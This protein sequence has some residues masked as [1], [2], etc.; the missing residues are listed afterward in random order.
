MAEPSD[1]SSEDGGY[2]R[3]ALNTLEVHREDGTV[4]DDFK[5]WAECVLLGLDELPDGTLWYA[6]S[7]VNLA[8]TSVTNGN[9]GVAYNYA[10][11]SKSV[12]LTEEG[13]TSL[14]NTRLVVLVFK[15][16][17]RDSGV[18]PLIATMSIPLSALHDTDRLKGAFPLLPPS[19]ALYAP[20]GI[21]TS[22]VAYTGTLSCEVRPSA[23][24]ERYMLG[25]RVLTL[26]NLRVSNLP[27][28]WI[29]DEHGK[30]AAGEYAPAKA[31]TPPTGATAASGS[32]KGAAAAAAHH[33]PTSSAGSS[34]G[35]AGVHVPAPPP[36]LS[37]LQPY[38]P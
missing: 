19:A 28:Q 12:V 8:R 3:I 9:E 35:A 24:L 14:L 29:L 17:A 11:K 21:H 33:P 37:P 1:I 34:K 13:V 10:R 22:S 16:G 7:D 5:T 4:E 23:Q 31:A 36:S 27:S 30:C 32:S 25:G 26:E 20:L 15:G 38:R 6:G 18:D 2:L